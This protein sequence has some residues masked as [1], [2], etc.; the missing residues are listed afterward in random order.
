MLP[1][2]A[3]ENEAVVMIDQRKLPQKEIYLRLKSVEQVARAIE[4]MTIRGAPAIG[5][6]AAYGLAL[7]VRQVKSGKTS[8]R[9]S[10]KLMS[11][12]G[13]HVQLPVISSGRSTE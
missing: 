7:A 12:C 1:T 5:L 8:A 3:W 9:L 4:N 2:I 6:A 10:G 13:E 11:G